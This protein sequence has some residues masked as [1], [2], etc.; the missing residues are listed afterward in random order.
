MND[1]YFYRFGFD[2]KP[3]A[4]RRLKGID[5]EAPTDAESLFGELLARPRLDFYRN[6][7]RG[8]VERYDNV[9]KTRA[10]V[11]LLQLCANKQI[12]QFEHY[13]QNILPSHPWVNI[14]IDNREGHKIIGVEKKGVFPKRK[15]DRIGTGTVCSLFTSTINKAIEPYGKVMNLQPAARFEKFREFLIRQVTTGGDRVKSIELTFPE[16]D[17]N[18][19]GKADSSEP[20]VLCR[21][22]A[23]LLGAI[24]GKLIANYMKG[25]AEEL[26]EK[27]ENI[28]TLAALVPR[29]DYDLNVR[30][31]KMGCYK[32]GQSLWAHFRPRSAYFDDFQMG[33]QTM[34]SDGSTGFRMMEWLDMVNEKLTEY[35]L[36]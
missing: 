10:G 30:F 33:Q 23:K 34:L 9:I 3:T 29:A 7:P 28:A 20:F 26:Q 32:A 16:K 22:I 18:E 19:D 2:D 12:R 14:V 36:P 15:G 8:G 27:M 35:D 5:G 31:K 25:D 17:K 6:D 4:E 1:F 21:K 11:T 24:N 13:Q